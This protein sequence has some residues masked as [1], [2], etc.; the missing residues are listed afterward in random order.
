MPNDISFNVEDMMNSGVRQYKDQARN[1]SNNSEAPPSKS[2]EDSSQ[3]S[4]ERNLTEEQQAEIRRR[5]AIQKEHQKELQKEAAHAVMNRGE[6]KPEYTYGVDEPS[7]TDKVL[8]SVENDEDDEDVID[9]DFAFDENDNRIGVSV[10]NADFINS[11][12]LNP[13][14]N[15]I[16]YDPKQE[17][18]DQRVRV[19]Y[20]FIDGVISYMTDNYDK[21]FGEIGRQAVIYYALLK[22]LPRPMGILFAEAMQSVTG[23][24]VV[25]DILLNESS[26]RS[27][28]KADLSDVLEEN[29]KIMKQMQTILTAIKNEQDESMPAMLYG[30]IWLLMD[31][32]NLRERIGQYTF[33]ESLQEEELYNNLDMLLEEGRYMKDREMTKK[34]EAF[35]RR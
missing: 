4:G 7:V 28:K 10:N 5:Q 24:N 23:M 20:N 1:S 12:K 18:S 27:P 15:T 16:E 14:E 19:S 32:M 34:N 26:D 22:M 29:V 31:R 6:N 8:A 25:Y 33:S 35:R 13:S 30:M 17:T 21:R 9:L 2:P 11:F 3:Q